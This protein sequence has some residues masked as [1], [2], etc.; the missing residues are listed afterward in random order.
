MPSEPSD[1]HVFISSTSEDLKPYRAAARETIQNI[2]WIPV[3][4]EDFGAIPQRTVHACQ[5]ELA[6]CQVVLLIQAWRRGWVPT[7]E[8][9]GNGCDS[10]TALEI[11][12]A[13]DPQHKIDVLAMLASDNWPGKY[14]EN[15]DAAAHSWVKGFRNGLNLPAEFFD[16]EDISGPMP[17]FRNKVRKVLL[18]HKQRLLEQQARLRLT[19]GIDFFD[20][21]RN[22]IVKPRSVPFVGCGIYGDGPL[23]GPALIKALLKG[24]EP[25]P[26]NGL[27]EAAEYREHYLGDRSDFL[28]E[29][30][31]IVAT[32]TE[33]ASLPPV[34][35][36]LVQ[37]RTTTLVVVATYDQLL[38]QSLREAGRKFAVV[39]HIHSVKNEKKNENDG[40]IMVFR[41]GAKPKMCLA[42]KV[43]LAPD[44]LWVYRPLGSPLLHGALDPGIETVV[45]TETD[46]AAFLARLENQKTGI[47]TIFSRPMQ[48]KRFLFLGY[49]LDAWHYRLVTRLIHAIGS[50]PSPIA[51]RKLASHMEELAWKRLKADL[52]QSDPNEF[53]TRVLAELQPA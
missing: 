1:I 43:E 30:H 6:K 31:D 29:L 50:T 19:G 47:P 26:I 21:A 3:M 18:A 33:Q 49:G 16:P 14:W 45:I 23:G 7:P 38:E 24:E 2:R 51:V 36:M 11:A 28:A 37:L 4:M 13:K 48:E 15:D 32:Q 44:E 10:M 40:A 17:T 52:A 46:H 8:Q 42:D 34:L 5:E 25:E 41:D 22:A 20:S 12:Y 27:A 35:E 53:A 9:G 39:A